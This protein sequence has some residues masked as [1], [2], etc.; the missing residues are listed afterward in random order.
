MA[1]PKYDVMVKVF[2][3]DLL[4]QV[5]SDDPKM[6]AAKISGVEGINYVIG[7][8][9]SPVFAYLDPRYDINEVAEEIE[10]IFSSEALKVFLE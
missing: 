4:I 2:R 6:S 3:R 8:P 10:E 5:W 1:K 9:T 7:G